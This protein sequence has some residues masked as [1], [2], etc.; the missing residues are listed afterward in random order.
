MTSRALQAINRAMRAHDW[1]D[2]TPTVVE[3]VAYHLG[4]LRCEL[5]V[6]SRMDAGLVEVVWRRPDGTVTTGNQVPSCEEG[7]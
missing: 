3:G 4:C 5:V 6:G 1:R 7:V 2:L